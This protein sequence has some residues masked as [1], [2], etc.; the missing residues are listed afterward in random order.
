[1][2]LDLVVWNCIFKFWTP[3]EVMRCYIKV[4]RIWRF[5][6]LHVLLGYI[7]VLIGVSVFIFD[8]CNCAETFPMIW[9]IWDWFR[10]CSQRCRCR[11]YWL[12]IILNFKEIGLFSEF[13]TCALTPVPHIL[14]CLSL[15]EFANICLKEVLDWI[16]INFVLDYFLLLFV[17]LYLD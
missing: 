10:I 7:W 6:N 13:F 14:F 15:T 5:K 1:M 16:L 9:W 4:V 11:D 8:F 3:D 12:I 17:L 2:L